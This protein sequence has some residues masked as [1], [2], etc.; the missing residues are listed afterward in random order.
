MDV[1]WCIWG[2]PKE[3]RAWELAVRQPWSCQSR[4]NSILDLYMPNSGD[5]C[6]LILSPS[7]SAQCF[8]LLDIIWPCDRR[9]GCRT[10]RRMPP[11]RH[12]KSRRKP[13]AHPWGPQI[14]GEHPR[15]SPT[16]PT[17]AVEFRTFRISN[18]GTSQ[19]FVPNKL[20]RKDLELH[21]KF[22]FLKVKWRS[23]SRPVLSCQ[24][25]VSWFR[26]FCSKLVSIA[27]A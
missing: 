5:I 4:G 26:T 25:V 24:T 20:S 23:I 14:S 12:A 1:S 21:Q 7:P 9:W 10:M 17:E 13:T 22:C 18:W 2:H 8:R 3:L 11:P 19:H 6:E 27:T 16:W 15:P